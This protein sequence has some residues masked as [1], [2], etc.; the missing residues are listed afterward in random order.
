MNNILNKKFIVTIIALYI[1]IL[2]SD[3]AIITLEIPL[4]EEYD[5]LTY[6]RQYNGVE[7]FT[8]IYDDF[9]AVGRKEHNPSILRTD[10]T[11]L[12]YNY[13]VPSNGTITNVKLRLKVI[14]YNYNPG[15]E[16]SKI[17]IRKLGVTWDR[18]WEGMTN[19]SQTNLL[20]ANVSLTYN[21]LTEISLD[22]NFINKQ[23]L[24]LALI[25]INESDYQKWMSFDISS[26][27]LVIQYEIP[28]QAPPSP[29]GLTASNIT[30][31]SFKLS[32]NAV[33]DPDGD[34]VTYQVFKNDAAY[35]SPTSNTYLS[36]TGGITP[37]TTYSMTVKA[38]DNKGYESPASAVKPVTAGGCCETDRTLVSPTHDVSSGTRDFLASNSITAGN[39]ISGTAIVHIGAN[40]NIRLIPGFKANTGTRL[41]VDLIGC[42][43]LKSTK[44]YSE[45]PEDNLRDELSGGIY[46]YPNPSDGLIKMNFAGIEGTKL[47]YI[48]NLAGSLVFQNQESGYETDINLQDHPKGIYII[49]VIHENGIYQNKL[50]IE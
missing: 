38:K 14:D 16:I 28:N 25:N 24:E 21:Q 22:K 46:F 18:S 7:Y 1:S 26:S 45:E 15:D 48:N 40:G 42:A 23:Q 34:P 33:V 35:G 6:E 12:K 2:N 17:N 30:N 10:R 19:S 44:K 49:K 8:F 13:D 36:I 29:T 11:Y 27:V 9:I 20:A 43:A 41:K 47:I 39:K 31:T 4:H 5:R 50:M 32:W 37:C 3:A